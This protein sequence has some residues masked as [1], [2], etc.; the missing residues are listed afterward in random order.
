MTPR[1]RVDDWRSA[2]VIDA[3]DGIAHAQDFPE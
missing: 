3:A 1:V 2:T